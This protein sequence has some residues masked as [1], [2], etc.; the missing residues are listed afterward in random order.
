MGI[1]RAERPGEVG[2]GRS[3]RDAG[4]R[5]L[6]V[7][8]GPRF[9]RAGKLRVRGQRGAPPTGAAD[10]LR[11]FFPEIRARLFDKLEFVNFLFASLDGGHAPPFSPKR[12]SPHERAVRYGTTPLLGR[13]R[14]DRRGP[15]G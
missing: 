13:F 9:T 12:G 6:T 10:K 2:L 5:K 11:R 8:T 15:E 1:E 4:R 7:R 14:L 3:K